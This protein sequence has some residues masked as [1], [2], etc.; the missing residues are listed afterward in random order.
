MEKLTSEYDVASML[1]FQEILMVSVLLSDVFMVAIFPQKGEDSFPAL[2]Q[3]L[4]K[5]STILTPN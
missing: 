4:L 2:Y 3:S 1:K 5:R